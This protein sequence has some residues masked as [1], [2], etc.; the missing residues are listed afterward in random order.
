MNTQKHII[1]LWDAAQTELTEK[2]RAINTDVK[3]FSKKRRSQ[4]DYL[5]LHLKEIEKQEQIKTKASTKKIIIK[6]RSEIN[7][8]DNTK[9][10]RGK[11]NLFF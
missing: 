3:K 2:F 10:N 8:I 9:K 4:T 6:V 1:K 7:K 5:T 11:Q